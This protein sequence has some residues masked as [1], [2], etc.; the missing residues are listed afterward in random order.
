MDTSISNPKRV[1]RIAV[2]CSVF[3]SFLQFLIYYICVGFLYDNVFVLMAAP[4]LV[5][6]LEA[7]FPVFSA[8][9]VFLIKD[10]GLKNKL[11]PLALISLPRILY[12][13]PY[14]YI[15]YVTDVFNTAEALVIALIL[16]VVYLLFFFLQTFV[17]TFIMNYAEFKSAPKNISR[18]PARIFNFDNSVNFGI[19]L[20]VIFMF[21]I[22]FARECVDTVTYFVEVGSTYYL[23]E[24]MSIILSYAMLPIFAFIHY[25]ICVLLKNRI[26]REKETKED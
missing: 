8:V 1:F 25:L 11:L 19:L 4:H 10:T 13:F 12:T 21:V 20:S 2:I 24:I 16:S 5:N 23:N 18:T 22:F 15:R 6:F 26:T 9:I 7:L 17:C 14:Y 3:F